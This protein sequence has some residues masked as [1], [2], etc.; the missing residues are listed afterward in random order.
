MAVANVT[1]MDIDKL[2]SSLVNMQLWLVL[3]AAFGLG[4]IGAL[5]HRGSLEPL[6]TG[7]RARDALTGGVAAVAILYVTSPPSGVALIGGSVVAGYAGKLVLAGLEARVTATLA[8]REAASHE[9]AARHAR[10][11]L[12][13]LA[14]RV[15]AISSAPAAAPASDDAIADVQR[16]AR[17]LQAK[18][19]LD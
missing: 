17:E 9:L 8:L 13:R 3:A 5:V 12:D 1:H 6:P 2:L 7:G 19:T 4:A 14:I 18:H 15:A 16:F 10:Q 11:D